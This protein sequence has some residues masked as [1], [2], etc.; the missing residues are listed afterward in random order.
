[1]EPPAATPL[2]DVIS[3]LQDSHARLAK[4]LTTSSARR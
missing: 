3:A 1:M 4:A 2:D